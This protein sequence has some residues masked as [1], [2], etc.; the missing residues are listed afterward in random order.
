MGAADDS[1][2]SEH[3]S[4]CTNPAEH[5]QFTDSHNLTVRC[6]TFHILSVKFCRLPTGSSELIT[7]ST[8]CLLRVHNCYVPNN[9]LSSSP[10]FALLSLCSSPCSALCSSLCSSL[11]SICSSLFFAMYFTIFFTMF[12]SIFSLCSLRFALCFS[13]FGLCLSVLFHCLVHNVFHYVLHYFHYVCSAVGS[14]LCSAVCFS[15]LSAVRS[16]LL[17]AVLSSLCSAPFSPDIHY[18]LHCVTLRV[19]VDILTLLITNTAVFWNVTPF[20]SVDSQQSP[21]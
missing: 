21:G 11:L 19:T 5:N 6:I 8:D 10:C 4:R 20:S 13:L 3:S 9:S 15:L 7:D 1:E 18:G 12:C 14:S 17:S 2:P 16:S